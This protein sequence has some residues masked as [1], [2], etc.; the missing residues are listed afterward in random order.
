[1][2]SCGGKDVNGA[3]SA[4]VVDHE[5][6]V[7]GI[8]CQPEGVGEPGVADLCQELPMG[9]EEGNG[10]AVSV[11]HR[12]Y[13]FRG[14]GANAAGSW[15]GELVQ[16]VAIFVKDL[17]SVLV[18]I[19]DK[20]VTLVAHAHP[21]GVNELPIAFAM[22]AKG[23]QPSPLRGKDLDSVVSRISDDQ[24]VVLLV[25]GNVVR[26]IKLPRPCPERAKHKQE[27]ALGREAVDPVVASLRHKDLSL[28]IH[29][30]PSKALE[31]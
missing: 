26:R 3:G 29:R 11:C 27:P 20:D 2:L 17:H 28:S 19:A 4:P 13:P 12:D 30:H 1:M 9:G 31:L 21:P 16:V 5:D 23:A 6:I 10:S 8:M 24:A 25:V 22:G 18:G 7:R 14:D 15:G